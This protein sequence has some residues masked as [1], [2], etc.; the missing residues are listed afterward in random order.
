MGNAG[1]GRHRGLGKVKTFS[2]ILGI[3]I[4]DLFSEGL[5]SG[6]HDEA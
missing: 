4:S 3:N 5:K 2:D 1:T 6:D